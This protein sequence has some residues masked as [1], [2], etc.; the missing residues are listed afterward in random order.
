METNTFP[1]DIHLAKLLGIFIIIYNKIFNLI[2]SYLFITFKIGYLIV[3]IAFVTGLKM[4]F[5]FVQK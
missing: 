5:Q 4:Y 3:D 1:I 2:Y